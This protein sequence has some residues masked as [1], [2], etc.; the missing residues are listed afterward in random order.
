QPDVALLNHPTRT[1]LRYDLLRRL[2][3]RGINNFKARRIDPV[4]LDE[5]TFPLFL[6]REDNHSGPITPLILSRKEL[7]AQVIRLRLSGYDLNKVI[8]IEFLESADA[9]GIYSKYG[10]Y[11]VGDRVLPRH[12]RFG[13]DWMV[14][15]EGQPDSRHL[16][17]EMAYIDENPHAEIIKTIADEARVGYG[18]IDYSMVGG[19]M[20]VWEINTNPHIETARRKKDPNVQGVRIKRE[21]EFFSAFSDLLMSLDTAPDRTF[22]IE[23]VSSTPIPPPRVPLDMVDRSRLQARFAR[24]PYETQMRSARWLRLLGGRA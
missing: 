16:A 6:R 24:L 7:A 23:A 10:A 1:L 14:K 3:V 11:I 9:E 12:L 20:Q 22:S 18:R 13:R 5:L 4:E 8:A 21:N 2:E 19:R 17:Q 15:G